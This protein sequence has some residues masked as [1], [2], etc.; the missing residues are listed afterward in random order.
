[1]PDWAKEAIKPNG[2]MEYIAKVNYKFRGTPQLVRIRIGFLI[3]DMLERFSQKIDGN[4]DPDRVLWMYSAHSS[5][6][7]TLLNGLG[8]AGVN[9]NSLNQNC[10]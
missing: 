5:T 2:V 9:N 10:S 4:L 7:G 6:M 8:A 3:R 1:M